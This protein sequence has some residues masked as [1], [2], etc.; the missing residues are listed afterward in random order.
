MKTNKMMR[1]ASVLL[2]AVL[3][4]TCVISGTFA[5]Y[6][7]TSTA[8]ATAKIAKWQID[9]TKKDGETQE[10]TFDLFATVNDTLNGNDETDVAD[11]R[12]APGTEGSFKIEFTNN[13]EVNV[14]YF[15]E[16]FTIS[17]GAPADLKFC[18]TEDGTYVAASA[19]AAT[20]NK[21]TVNMNNKGELTVYWM[22]DFG[23]DRVDNAYSALDVTVT[24]KVTVEQVD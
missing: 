13:S 11:E 21:T 18:T 8:E 7:T 19:F 6:T 9:F 22:W 17:E 12:I 4:T 24:A 1:I 23:E 15:M 2:V 20:I 3:L 10:F 16:S 14:Q 5:K